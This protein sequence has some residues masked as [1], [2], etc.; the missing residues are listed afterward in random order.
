M[1]S[2]AMATLLALAAVLFT[3]AA[4]SAAG[5]SAFGPLYHEYQLTLR[6]GERTELIGPLWNHERSPTHAQ[7]AF[8]PILSWHAEFDTDFE[9]YDFL[10]PLLTYNRTGKDSRWQL[11]QLIS[12]SSLSRQDAAPPA[13][14]TT[15]FPFYWSQRSPNPDENYTA[16]FPFYGQIKNR[17]LRDEIEFLLFPFYAKTRKHDVVTENYLFPFF[18]VRHGEKLEGWQFWP[19]AGLEKKEATRR[20]D[21]FGDETV[22]GGHEKLFVLWP[23]YH[24]TQTGLGTTN[25]QT[26]HAFLPFFATER[27]AQREHRSVLWP[28][29]YRT[30]DHGKKFVE[31]GAPWPFIVSTRGEAMNGGRFWPFYGQTRTSTRTNEFLFAALYRSS[32]SRAE[33]LERTHDRYLFFLY[34]DVH[35]RNTATGATASRHALWPLFTH[36]RE[37]DGTERLQLLAPLEPLLSGNAAIERNWSPLWA[38]WRDEKNRKT[39]AT[40]Q[41]LLWNL[42][43]HDETPESKNCSLLF[44]LLQYQKDGEGTRWRL[45][46][47]PFGPEARPAKP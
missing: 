20:Q 33:P 43:R 2:R 32:R 36:R 41:S 34:Q 22:I 44:G 18:H 39:G 1:M 35:E 21:G 24:H 29:F 25:A 27:S 10:Y 5:P 42:Y 13:E 16:L 9:E 11:F 7:W 26:H 4:P 40:S 15:I 6:E 3:T 47:I 28:F 46:F 8:P 30:E 12:F 38:L 14:R 45:F 23:F 37:L 17:L 31:Y 19:L